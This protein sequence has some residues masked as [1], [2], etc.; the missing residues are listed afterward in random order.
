VASAPTEVAIGRPA[1]PPSQEAL[2]ALRKA[3]S[4]TGADSVH[5]FWVS[6][7]GDPPH[8]GLGVEPGS[9]AVANAVAKAVQ[10]A[11][12]RHSPSNQAVDVF[13]LG[14]ERLDQAIFHMGTMLWS[15]AER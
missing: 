4:S 9:E 10:Q 11:W 14:D 13:R 2:D 5:W 6:V 15:R 7:A 8:L 1:D 12:K 3:I